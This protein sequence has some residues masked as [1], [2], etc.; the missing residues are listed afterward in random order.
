LRDQANRSIEEKNMPL[1]QVKMIEGVF[2]TAKKKEIVTKLTDTM[3]A[4]EGEALRPYT[5]VLLEET[6]QP[7]R[8]PAAE[9]PRR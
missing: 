3:V 2:T 8:F 9:F 7:L 5:V 4:I 1:I 6:G